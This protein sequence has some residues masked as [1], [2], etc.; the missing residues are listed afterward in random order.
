MLKDTD[1]FEPE[2]GSSNNGEYGNRLMKSDYLLLKILSAEGS[3]LLSK[4]ELQNKTLP[5]DY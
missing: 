4:L 1:P 5:W 3:K 2:G